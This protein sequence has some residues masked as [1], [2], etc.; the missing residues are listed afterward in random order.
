[1]EMEQ[2]RNWLS[3]ARSAAAELEALE[4]NQT[5]INSRAVS[6]TASYS[7]DHV[8]GTKDPHKMDNYLDGV[9]RYSQLIERR[10]AALAAI[11][12]EIFRV[13]CQ[14]PEGKERAVLIRRYLDCSSWEAIAEAMRYTRRNISRLHGKALLSIK[15]ILEAR[16]N[17][18]EPHRN[19]P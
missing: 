18:P 2:V 9:E 4:E 14:V 15:S 19:A 11:S 12:E 6:V 7:G 5:R 10:I 17:P 3:R 8:S 16:E 1:M 13:V